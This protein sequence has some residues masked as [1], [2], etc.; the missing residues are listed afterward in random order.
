MR[1]NLLFT[2]VIGLSIAATIVLSSIAWS[3]KLEGLILQLE[4]AVFEEEWERARERFIELRDDWSQRRP[5]AELTNSVDVTFQIDRLFARLDA[6]IRTESRTQ[7]LDITAD[8]K[9]LWLDV[10]R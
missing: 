10:K 2:V 4:D 6:A 8:L 9:R 1:K 7:A 3:T 5:W